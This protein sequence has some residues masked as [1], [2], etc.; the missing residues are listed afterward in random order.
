[1]G[2]EKS[3]AEGRDVEKIGKEKIGKREMEFIYRGL[4]L[5]YRRLTALD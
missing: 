3:E 1:M 2:K 4:L 5:S